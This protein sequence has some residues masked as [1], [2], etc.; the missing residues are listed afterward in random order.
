M[1]TFRGVGGLLGV[2]RVAAT[3]NPSRADRDTAVAL[4]P[5]WGATTRRKP[6]HRGVLFLAAVDRLSMS[7]HA[8]WDLPSGCRHRRSGCA[9]V[10]RTGRCHLAARWSCAVA[11]RT[12][13]VARR[14]SPSAWA[15]RGGGRAGGTGPCRIV[16]RVRAGSA[17]EPALSAS[18]TRGS[19][20]PCAGRGSRSGGVGRSC[21]GRGSRRPAAW[22]VGCPCPNRG[23]LRRCG[24]PIGWAHECRGT[25]SR[26]REDA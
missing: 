18:S 20:R 6:A 2:G 26:H 1:P 8:R 10:T 11:G 3:P 22:G 16:R 13:P 19:W 23:P 4:P 14:H 15:P 9:F 5:M 21:E 12:P 25:A 7:R 24:L 17:T